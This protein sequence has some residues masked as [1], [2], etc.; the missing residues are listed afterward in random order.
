MYILCVKKMEFFI[1][2]NSKTLILRIM[3]FFLKEPFC[4]NLINIK[5]GTFL[6]PFINND[7]KLRFLKMSYIT[8]NVILLKFREIYGL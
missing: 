6:G 5:R 1:D 7:S 3:G 2:H 8:R 4:L